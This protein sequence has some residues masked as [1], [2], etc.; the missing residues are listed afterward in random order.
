MR[1]RTEN[2]ELLAADVTDMVTKPDASVIERNTCASEPLVGD[3]G[4]IP[5]IIMHD[6]YFLTRHFIL[7]AKFSPNRHGFRRGIYATMSPNIAPTKTVI[8]SRL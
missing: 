5:P 6:Q 8:V 4:A 2:V 3:T 1:R 7:C